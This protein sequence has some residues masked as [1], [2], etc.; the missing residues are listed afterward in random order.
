MS[1]PVPTKV[2]YPPYPMH[3][4]ALENRLAGIANYH[5]DAAWFWIGAWHIIALAK[6]NRVDE[7]RET[8]SRIFILG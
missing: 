8:L 4:V 3:L 6:S 1:T 7:A 2:A 5:T